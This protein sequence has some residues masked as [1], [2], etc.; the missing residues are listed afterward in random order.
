MRQKKMWQ[1]SARCSETTSILLK[2]PEGVKGREEKAGG[3]E[4]QS[5]AK[6]GGEGPGGEETEWAEGG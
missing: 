5:G 2:N 6:G 1:F 3:I 4:E